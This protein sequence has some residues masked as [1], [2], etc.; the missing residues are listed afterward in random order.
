[1]INY[2]LQDGYSVHSVK[3]PATSI[4][5]T[6]PASSSSDHSA[7]NT[8]IASSSR[9]AVSGEST[10]RSEV[11]NPSEHLSL[12][13]NGSASSLKSGAD[14]Y[15]MST[16]QQINYAKV[17]STSVLSIQQVN[18]KHAGNYTCAPSNARPVSI[19]VHVLRGK[20]Q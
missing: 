3:G 18:F 4:L 11:A 13:K 10:Q 15:L 20:Q 17:L 8:T 14:T 19:T 6:V 9:T 5:A 1:M 16:G 12:D 2:D 7:T